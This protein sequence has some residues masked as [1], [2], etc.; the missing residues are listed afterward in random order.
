[1]LCEN[2]KKKFEFKGEEK[3]QILSSVPG[4]HSANK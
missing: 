1:M 3:I 4:R 2:I